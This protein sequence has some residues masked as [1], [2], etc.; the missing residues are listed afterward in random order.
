MLFGRFI[1]IGLT[2]EQILRY[3]HRSFTAV[4]GLWFLKSEERYGF[5]G[6]LE[7]DRRVWEV[8]PKI[9]ARMIKSF[10]K[11][12]KGIDSLRDCLTIKLTLDGFKFKAVS[13]RKGFEIVINECPWHIILVQSKRSSVSAIIGKTICSTEYSVWAAEF[14]DSISFDFKNRICEG[15]RSCILQFTK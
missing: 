5:D 3:F 10:R 15:A 6:A 12:D 4:D 1:M 8:L 9:Q 14:D 2:D 7:T 11:L 13:S